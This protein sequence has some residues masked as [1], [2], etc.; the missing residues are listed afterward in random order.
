MI[1]PP[2]ATISLSRLQK[3]DNSSGEGGSP[4]LS[5][6]GEVHILYGTPAGLSTAGLTVLRQGNANPPGR[7]TVVVPDIQERGDG[8]GSELAAG[9]FDGDGLADL[10]VVA[11]NDAAGPN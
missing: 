6:A 1:P 4:D 11:E 7:S 9:D 2:A 5:H 8:F 10:A 3:D